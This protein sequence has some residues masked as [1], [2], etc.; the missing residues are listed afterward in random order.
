MRNT[1]EIAKK[2]KHFSE[3][4]DYRTYEVFKSVISSIIC[5]RNWKQA[6]IANFSEKTLAQIEYFFRDAMWDFRLLNTLRVQWIRN[7]IE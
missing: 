1:I 4:F 7:K 3:I 5:L 6:D 2:I